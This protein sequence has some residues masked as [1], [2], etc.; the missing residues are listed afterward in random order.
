MDA[1]QRYSE[2]LMA[3]TLR[4]LPRGVYRAEDA[5]DDDG[6][7]D[8]PVPIRVAVHLA[9]WARTRRLHAARRRRSRAA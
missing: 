8:E 1:L 4:A 9:R 3:A 2:R 7:S 5:L 6:I